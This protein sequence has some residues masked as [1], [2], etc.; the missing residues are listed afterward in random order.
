M[1]CDACKGGNHRKCAG[2]CDCR[3]EDEQINRIV[4]SGIDAMLAET[5]YCNVL[6]SGSPEARMLTNGAGKE[7]LIV[8]IQQILRAHKAIQC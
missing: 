6:F 4:A 2:E 3:Q 5:I 8:F 7:V 1:T